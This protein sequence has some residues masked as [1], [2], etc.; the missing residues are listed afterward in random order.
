MAGCESGAF[1]GRDVV[2]Y[3]AIACP[4]NKPSPSDYKRLGMMRGKSTSSEWETVDATADQSPQNTQ[5]SLVTYKNVTFS[6]DGVSRKEAIYGQRELKRHQYNPVETS[7][8]PYVWFKIVSPIDI[9]EGCFLVPTWSDESPHD[10]VA[11]WSLEANSAGGVDIR[12]IPEEIVITKQPVDQTLTVGQTLTLSVEAKSTDGSALTYQW[13]KGNSNVSGGTAA[14][15]T[16]QATVAGDAGE[17]T[18]VIT[19]T[20][21]GSVTSSQATV[22]IS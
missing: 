3:Y 14:T 21:A 19:S 1:T 9:T 20:S 13:K 15:F 5:E 16:K 4:E 2:V 18:C 8:Q 17:Y 11:T 12:D 6:G 22:T 10:D 7:G